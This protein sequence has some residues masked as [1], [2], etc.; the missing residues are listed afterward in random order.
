MDARTRPSRAVAELTTFS[1]SP[2]VTGKRLVLDGNSK[3][4]SS[5]IGSRELSLTR[6][7][8]LAGIFAGDRH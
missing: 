1:P 6:L 4:S 5:E 2:V 7:V 8:F 3:K